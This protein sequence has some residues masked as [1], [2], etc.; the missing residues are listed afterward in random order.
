MSMGRVYHHKPGELEKLEWLNSN[1]TAVFKQGDVVKVIF[2]NW[3]RDMVV[4]LM[5]ALGYKMLGDSATVDRTI[6]LN[7]IDP[8][9]DRIATH[10]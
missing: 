3:R 6:D 9:S 7:K 1:G 5:T 8:Q 10:L 2:P 4:E